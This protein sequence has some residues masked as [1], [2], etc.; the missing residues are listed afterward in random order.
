[1]NQPSSAS[2]EQNQPSGQKQLQL[3][4]HAG[5]LAGK[6]FPIIST[7]TFGRDEENDVALDDEEVSRYHARLLRQGD[8]VL[9]EDL[10][11]TNGTFINGNRIEEQQKLQ[12]TDIVSVGTSIFGVKGFTAPKTV[13]TPVPE[14]D[15]YPTSTPAPAVSPPNVPPPRAATPSSRPTRRPRR[16]QSSSGFGGFGLLLVVAGVFFIITLL[17]ITGAIV[18]LYSQSPPPPVATVPN[19]TISAP[20]NNATLSL[21][22][23]ATIQA[24]AV[25]NNGI[26]RIELWV[27]GQKIDEEVS[28]LTQGQTTL[29]ASFQWTPQL[30]GSYTLE[31]R[32]YNTQGVVNPPAV[33]AV[34]VNDPTATDT[35][36]TPVADTPTLT[37]IAA[38]A[39]PPPPGIPSLL[40]LTDLNVRTGPG[41][42]YDLLG[43]IPAGSQ[44]EITGQDETRQWWQIRFAPAANGIGWVSSDPNFG[45]ALNVQNVPIAVSPPT[46]TPTPT[47]TPL[48]TPT[49]IPTETPTALP[50]TNTPIP[51]PT[52]TPTLVP[53]DTPVP[54]ETPT[55][56]ATNIVFE[57]TPREVEVGEC[58]SLRWDVTGV[59]EIYLQEIGVG[60]S[61]QET[62]CPEATTT[63][64]LRVLRLDDTVEVEEITVTV[65]DSGI[66]SSGITTVSPNSSVD[67]DDDGQADFTWENSDGIR[68]FEVTNGAQMAVMED[69]DSIAEIDLDDCEVV[70]YN[71]YTFIDASDDAP[72]GED[73]LLLNGRTIC[74][75]SSGGRLGTLRFP[76]YSIR[77]IEI[78]WVTWE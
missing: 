73:N 12:P 18:Y 76:N 30:P 58:V 33:V 64:R 52:A 72:T 56:E 26:A 22:T 6:G 63:Y 8:E 50:A 39:T 69:T 28:P 23:P 5:P 17:V 15:S 37:P 46:P 66:F 19:V 31:I 3:V 11:S 48:P 54:T 32:A 1:M 14:P 7:L 35:P 24:T 36:P 71:V 78:E 62:D 34:Q 68:H 42:N 21:N 65:D 57:V 20:A 77:D 70:D 13:G 29:A 45:E 43:L 49:D 59:K 44:A 47:E 16:Q 53:T 38:T 75:R 10:G 67:L 41:T 27:S 61:G 25:D 55:Q 60:G 9:I 2:A 40:A 51:Q 74:Y 4:V